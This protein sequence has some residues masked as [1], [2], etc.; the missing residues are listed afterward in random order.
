MTP[1]EKT[2]PASFEEVW[3]ATQKAFSAYPVQTNNIDLGIIESALIR[4]SQLWSAPHLEKTSF[5]GVRYRLLGRVIKG[6]LDKRKATKVIIEK[7][8]EMQKDFFSQSEP[9][10]SDGLEELAL[11]YRIQREIIIQR[12]IQKAFKD[13]QKGV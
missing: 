10:K 8:M 1:L 6:M 9:L 11:M 3:S 13:Q 12:A 2:F 5:S 7:R 4:G